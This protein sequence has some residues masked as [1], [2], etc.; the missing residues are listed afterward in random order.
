MNY[1]NVTRAAKKTKFRAC[2]RD[3]LKLLQSRF[4]GLE[5]GE[6]YKHEIKLQESQVKCITVPQIKICK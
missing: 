1:T 4:T 6:F 5:C 2:I 3:D